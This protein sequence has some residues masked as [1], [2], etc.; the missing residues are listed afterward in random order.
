MRTIFHF[1]LNGVSIH[2][3]AALNIAEVIN[4][5]RVASYSDAEET[6]DKDGYLSDRLQIYTDESQAKLNVR[7]RSIVIGISI[8]FNFFHIVIGLVQVLPDLT[9]CRFHLRLIPMGIA[10]ILMFMSCMNSRPCRTKLFA[11]KKAK[12]KGIKRKACCVALALGGLLALLMILIFVI[13]FFLKN[14]DRNNA[15]S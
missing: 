3:L 11:P 8:M 15:T 12:K 13:T 10:L 4:L 14:L 7:Y 1:I 2:T 5:E 9:N 6:F